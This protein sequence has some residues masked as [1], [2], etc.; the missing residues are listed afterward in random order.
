VA[1]KHGG[2]QTDDFVCEAE[3]RVEDVVGATQRRGRRRAP[4]A[5]QVGIDAPTTTVRAK[6]RLGASLGQAV[7]DA[8]DMPDQHRLT[9][10]V[11]A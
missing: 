1:D 6:G 4:H 2:F 8:G 7:F 5:R 11:L 10:T 3:Q 9:L